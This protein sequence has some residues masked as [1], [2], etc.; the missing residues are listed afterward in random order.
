MFWRRVKECVGLMMIGDGA[1]CL[2]FP[3]RHV[4]LWSGGPRV[5]REAMET[6][7]DHPRATRSLGAVSVVL[8][9]WLAQRQYPAIEHE[10]EQV[11]GPVRRA[12]RAL[13]ESLS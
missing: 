5:W 4:G 6:F 9:C 3:R 8:G 7:T 1:L 10:I 11:G 2:L 12:G 13:V